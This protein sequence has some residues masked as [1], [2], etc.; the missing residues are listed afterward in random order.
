MP[1]WLKLT[2]VTIHFHLLVSICGYLGGL[3]LLVGFAATSSGRISTG[4]GRYHLANLI[5]GTAL[6]VS[7]AAQA[8]WP[9]V[10]VNL[11][12]MGISVLTLTQAALTRSRSRAAAVAEVL[13][14]PITL[15][16]VSNPVGSAPAGTR[17]DFP[18]AVA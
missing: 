16:V 14:G 1:M 10:G 4:S 11:V 18:V 12:W 2:L 7:C 15:S 5:G 3:L 13:A 8:A 6:L 17:M 9:S